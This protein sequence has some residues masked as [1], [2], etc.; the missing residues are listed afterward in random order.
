MSSKGILSSSLTGKN[1]CELR[2]KSFIHRQDLLRHQ[3]TIHGEKT[4]KCHLCFF[5]CLPMIWRL[6]IGCPCKSWN[7]RPF[8]Q[9]N[10]VAVIL[11]VIWKLMWFS[12][13]VYV[14]M[15]KCKPTFTIRSM[16]HLVFGLCSFRRHGKS[17][18]TK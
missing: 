4:F 18:T 11:D 7:V 1:E 3:H 16:T 17:L 14:V 5:C 8:L 12:K 6:F 9:T 15:T 13:G 10:D 2:G